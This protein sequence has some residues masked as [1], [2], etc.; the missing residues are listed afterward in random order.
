MVSCIAGLQ[1]C[2]FE[3]NQGQL[4]IC[5]PFP[6]FACDMHWCAYVHWTQEGVDALCVLRA[7]CCVV[8]EEGRR[9]QGEMN[10]V[11]Q[12]ERAAGTRCQARDDAVIEVSDAFR[13]RQ[14]S[15]YRIPLLQIH[16]LHAL[17]T[18]RGAPARESLFAE[19]VF[20]SSAI[21]RAQSHL[22]FTKTCLTT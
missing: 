16:T 19:L 18:S 22:H 6:A 17:V 12:T 1:Y 11:C 14:S 5:T 9:A 20:L 7:A 8:C 13:C 3:N 10:R 4:Y 2:N 15:I 21:Q